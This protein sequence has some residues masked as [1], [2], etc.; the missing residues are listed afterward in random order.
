[1]KSLLNTLIFFFIGD[2]H[3]MLEQCMNNVTNSSNIKSADS[4]LGI[5]Y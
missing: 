4:L 5:L 3:D 2:E 1:M